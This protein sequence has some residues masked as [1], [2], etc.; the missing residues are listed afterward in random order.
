MN[1]IY[2]EGPVHN[3]LLPKSMF[4]SAINPCYHAVT[5]TPLLILKHW[6]IEDLKMMQAF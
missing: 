2:G 3:F 5:T 4:K 6:I 1:L